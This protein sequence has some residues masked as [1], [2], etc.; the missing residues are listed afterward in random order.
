MPL[1]ESFT[2]LVLSGLDSGNPLAFLAAVGTLRT[3][4]RADRSAEW[5]LSW[6]MHDGHWSPVLRSGVGGREADQVLERGQ[7]RH[8][9]HL[10]QVAFHVGPEVVGQPATGIDLAVMDVRQQTGRA[11]EIAE[12]PI[13]GGGAAS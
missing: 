9:F 8:P 3:A 5:R 2:A 4:T 1:H 6:T 10:A 11:L 13:R 7:V 12:E